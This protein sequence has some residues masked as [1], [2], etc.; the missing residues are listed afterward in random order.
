MSLLLCSE[1]YNDV[2]PYNIDERM[3]QAPLAMS[4]QILDST[5]YYTGI[6]LEYGPSPFFLK[7]L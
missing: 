5:I 7:L 2:L 4:K 1:T 3:M 6:Y